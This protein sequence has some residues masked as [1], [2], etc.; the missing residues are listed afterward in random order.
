MSDLSPLTPPLN[1]PLTGSS[2][3]H[4]ACERNLGEPRLGPPVGLSVLILPYFHQMT[5]SRTTTTSPWLTTPPTPL[6]ANPTSSRQVTPMSPFG[7]DTFDKVAGRRQWGGTDSD[8]LSFSPP[9]PMIDGMSYED[10][11]KKSVVRSACRRAALAVAS[12]LTSL[13]CPA[14]SWSLLPCPPPGAV[15]GELPGLRPGNSP[16]QEGQG[17]GRQD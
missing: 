14:G 8:V 16:V 12:D 10:L 2:L 1:S 11:V 7:L 5:T 4:P 6:G 15:P 17:L 9:E 3:H 13:S